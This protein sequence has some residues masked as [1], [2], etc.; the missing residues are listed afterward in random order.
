MIVN[1][2]FCKSRFFAKEPPLM[3]PEKQSNKYISLHF[4]WEKAHILE[5][6]FKEKKTP[7]LGFYQEVRG[8][9]EGVW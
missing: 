7:D 4:F 5:A 2:S 9:I 1:A 8:N 6:V 3:H